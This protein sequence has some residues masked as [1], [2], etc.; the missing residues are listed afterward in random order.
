MT[1]R[2]RTSLRRWKARCRAGRPVSYLA[3]VEYRLGA[4]FAFDPIRF[5]SDWYRMRRPSQAPPWR[6]ANVDA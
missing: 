1:K 3:I 4:W 5:G 6:R 2:K